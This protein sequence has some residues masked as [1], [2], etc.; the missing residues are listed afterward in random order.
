MTLAA[1]RVVVVLLR[2]AMADWRIALA[3]VGDVEVEGVDG[4]EEED[5]V[6][7]VRVNMPE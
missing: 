6:P 1:A 3:L 7:P 5:A 4:E 2:V